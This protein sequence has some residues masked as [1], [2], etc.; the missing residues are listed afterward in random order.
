MGQVLNLGWSTLTT[1][2]QKLLQ[3]VQ[4]LLDLYLSSPSASHECL[5]CPFETMRAIVRQ[6]SNP[7]T[8]FLNTTAHTQEVLAVRHRQLSYPVDQKNTE[9]APQH[10]LDRHELL[11]RSDPNI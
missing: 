7:P 10:A 3:Y 6:A 8:D 1:Q 5:S 11:V 2:D 4:T 9:S